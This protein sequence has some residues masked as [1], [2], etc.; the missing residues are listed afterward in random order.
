MNGTLYKPK[1]SEFHL[2]LCGVYEPE[3]SG[4]QTYGKFMSRHWEKTAQARFGKDILLTYD[5]EKYLSAAAWWFIIKQHYPSIH[6]SIFLCSFGTRSRGLFILYLREY[7]TSLQRKII[8]AVCIL[9]LPILVMTQ[10]MTIG[11]YWNNERIVNLQNY[12]SG[13]VSEMLCCLFAES[14]SLIVCNSF[15][16]TNDPNVKETL[17]IFT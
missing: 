13:K 3:G 6:S 8:S 1:K 2:L 15:T 4:P 10:I 12:P 14:E 7:P 5:R 9:D 16:A 17:V 11:E